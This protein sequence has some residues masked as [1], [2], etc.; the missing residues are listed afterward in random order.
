MMPK[1]LQSLAYCV[2]TR[3][4]GLG[5]LYEE[6]ARV[7][8]PQAMRPPHKPPVKSAACRRSAR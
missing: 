3:E 8:V 1:A 4:P 5:R 7:G 6:G 2:F